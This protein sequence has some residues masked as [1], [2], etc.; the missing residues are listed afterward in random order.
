MT[1]LAGVGMLNRLANLFVLFGYFRFSPFLTR[2]KKEAVH[3]HENSQVEQLVSGTWTRAQSYL[4]GLPVP[5]FLIVTAVSGLLT[6]LEDVGVLIRSSRSAIRF[7]RD[8]D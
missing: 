1:E 4:A 5:S 7:L 3:C 6:G 8:P 2:W